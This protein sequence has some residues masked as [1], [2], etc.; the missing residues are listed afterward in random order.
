MEP[1]PTRAEE[2]CY[3]SGHPRTVIMVVTH[4]VFVTLSVFK[5]AASP[6]TLINRCSIHVVRPVKSTANYRDSKEQGAY[7]GIK[8][9]S[10]VFAPNL[11]KPV[12]KGS[13]R[14]SAGWV[15]WTDC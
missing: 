2:V 5:N 4:C 1:F 6:F 12:C 7:L 11:A 8:M 13:Q 14:T 9:K 10:P 15:A 3:R